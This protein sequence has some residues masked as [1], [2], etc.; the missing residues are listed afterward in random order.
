MQHLIK[1]I[2]L[3]EALYKPRPA[4]P[5]LIV[6][7]YQGETTADVLR[8]EGHNDEGTGGLVLVFRRN[9]RSRVGAQGEHR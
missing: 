5:C 7:R 4:R 3:L 9:H 1:R 8:I 6:H 2:A